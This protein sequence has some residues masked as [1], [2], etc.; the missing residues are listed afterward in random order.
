MPKKIKDFK[1]VGYMSCPALKH[2]IEQQKGKVVSAEGEGLYCSCNHFL[3]DASIAATFA[4]SM[5]EQED[6][7]IHHFLEGYSLCSVTLCTTEDK[8]A[9][10]G[11]LK[12]ILESSKKALIPRGEYHTKNIPP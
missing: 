1:A 5:N 8:A 7:D 11:P 3:G 2:Y 4:V 10:H 6:P 12:V 9:K